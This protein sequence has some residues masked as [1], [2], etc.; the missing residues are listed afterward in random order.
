M[1]IPKLIFNERELSSENGY[2]RSDAPLSFVQYCNNDIIQLLLHT[3]I[4]ILNA[5][6][7]YDLNLNAVFSVPQLFVN[8]AKTRINRLEKVLINESSRW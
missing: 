8:H 7:L 6:N 1:V 5:L 4:N 3:R 2:H